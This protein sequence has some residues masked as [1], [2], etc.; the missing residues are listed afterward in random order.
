MPHLIGWE[1]PCHKGA[2]E[3]RLCSTRRHPSID[4]PVAVDHAIA[5]PDVALPAKMFLTSADRISRAETGLRVGA[6]AQA[7]RKWCRRFIERDV[8]GSRGTT[9]CRR[10][11]RPTGV[12]NEARRF[13]ARFRRNTILLP[14][15]GWL[16]GIQAQLQLV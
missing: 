15:Q 1:E 13:A 2:N 12:G 14:C 11:S 10:G 4:R 8:D 5:Q 3:R 16:Q 6:S 7:L 9:R